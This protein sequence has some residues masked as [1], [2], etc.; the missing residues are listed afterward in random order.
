MCASAG[1]ASGSGSG[2]D[3]L[4][5]SFKGFVS[6]SCGECAQ[7]DLDFARSGDG[8]WDVSWKFVECPKG[9]EPSFIFEGSN[10]WYW[11]IQPRE[12]GTPVTQLWVN[13][14]EATMTQDNFFTISNGPYK[15]K[16]LVEFK[17]Y[18]GNT[19]SAYVSQ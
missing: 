1:T 8:R 14:D 11:K 5:S 3:P 7:G 18:D 6:D 10:E 16:Q 4:P 15:G 2:H 13:G 12:T 19:E 9:G 17:K